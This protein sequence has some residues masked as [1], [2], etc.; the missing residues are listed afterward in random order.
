MPA[1]L[2]FQILSHDTREDYH[3]CVDGV[4]DSVVGEVETVCDVGGDPCWRAIRN[5]IPSSSQ[6]YLGEENSVTEI[7]VSLKGFDRASPVVLVNLIEPCYASFPVFF[8]R[9][10]MFTVCLS[11]L[12]HQVL[13]ERSLP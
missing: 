4:E 3:F 2:L 10:P 1:S 5:V 9:L 7:F 6:R 12:E 11:Y 8:P 13:L